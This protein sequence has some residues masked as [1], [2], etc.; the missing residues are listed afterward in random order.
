MSIEMPFIT[1]MYLI[2]LDH[3]I[4][5]DRCVDPDLTACPADRLQP[6]I[7]QS[8]QRRANDFGQDGLH[9][10]KPCRTHG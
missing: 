10:Y 3:T 2:Q 7:H 1:N 5:Q 6:L 8:M 4:L 9:W